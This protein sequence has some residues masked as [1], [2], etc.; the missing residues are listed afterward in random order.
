MSNPSSIPNHLTLFYPPVPSEPRD[1]QLEITKPGSVFIKWLPPAQPNGKINGYIIMYSTSLETLDEM[2]VSVQRNGSEG[3]AT[4]NIRDVA[5]RQ[6]Y[7]KVRASTVKG[8]GLPTQPIAVDPA[9]VKGEGCCHDVC[10]K[11]VLRR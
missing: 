11:F 8:L 1:V 6:Y 2:W 9:T 7:F 10:Q 5:D 4:I 3:S